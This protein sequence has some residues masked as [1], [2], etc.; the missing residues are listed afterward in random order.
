MARTKV[1]A[2]W[3]GLTNL[4]A[5]RICDA[6]QRL[7]DPS[8]RTLKSIRVRKSRSLNNRIEQDHRRVK[9]CTRSS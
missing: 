3:V 1:L 5:I 8:R 7:R 4:E 9:R 6:K 2:T